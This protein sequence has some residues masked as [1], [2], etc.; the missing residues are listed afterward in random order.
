M[1]NKRNQNQTLTNNV[2]DNDLDG[3]KICAGKGCN[4]IGNHVLSIIYI[5]KSGLF[6]ETCKKELEKCGLV[7][8]SKSI[9]NGFR[10]AEKSD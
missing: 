1:E 6:C 9:K 4:N 10:E 3:Y 2:F 8:L 7:L 5:N